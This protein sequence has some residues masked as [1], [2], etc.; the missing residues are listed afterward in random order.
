MSFPPGSLVSARGREW[1]VL[2]SEEG[3]VLRVRPLAGGEDEIAGL[4]MPLEWR[5]IAPATF[6]PP[7]PEQVGDAASA[8]VLCDA[9]RLKLRSGAAPFRS[10]GRVSV[11]PRPYQFV[12]LIMALRLDPVR[13]LI[14]DDVGVGKTIEAA[15]VAREMLDRGLARRLAVICPAHLCDQWERELHEKFALEAAVVQPAR[16]GRLER[17]LPRSDL[18]LYAHYRHLVVSIDFIKTDKNRHAFLRNAPDLIIVDEAHTAARPAGGERAVQQRYEFLKALTADPTRHILLVTATPHSGIEES[19][20]SLLGLLDPRFDTAAEVNRRDLVPHLVQRRRRDLEERWLGQDH[21]FPRRESS[22]ETYTLSDEYAALYVDVL[23]YCRESVSGSP[24]L[25]AQQQR[26]RYWAALALLRCVLSSPR[27]AAAVLSGRAKRLGDETSPIFDTADDV[28][29]TYLPQVLDPLDDEAAGD[30]TPSAPVDETWNGLSDT[31]RRRLTGLIR[32]AEQLAGP[33]RDHK[34]ARLIALLTAQLQAGAHPIVFCRFIA[35]AD[36]LEEQLKAALAVSFPDLAVRAVT[37]AAGG[38]DVRRE[39]IADLAQHERRV[40]VATD[41]LSEG[42]NLQDDF[43]AVLHYDLPWNPNRLE[44]REGRVDRFGQPRP[45]VNAV[46]LY[47]ANNEVDLVV[48]D[49]LL[50][51]AKQIRARLGVAVPVPYESEHV[52]G[53]LVETVLL[54]RPARGGLQLQLGLDHQQ[55]SR[56]HQAWD[57]AADREAR[58]RSY[59]AQQGIDPNEVATELAATDP[60]LGNPVTVEMFLRRA[61]QRLGGDLLPG[62]LPAVFSFNPGQAAP[63]LRARTGNAFPLAVTLDRQAASMPRDRQADRRAEYVGRTHPLV[64]GL[65]DLVLGRALGGDPDPLFARTGAIFTRAVMRR[66]AVALLRIRYN[67]RDPGNGFAEEVLLAAFS[68]ETDGLTWLTPIEQAG[69]DLI[70]AAEPAANM[71]N[72]E[73]TEHVRWA[74]DQLAADAGWYRPVVDARVAALQGAHTRLRRLARAPKL[75][76]QPHDP[77]DILGCYVL[78]PAAGGR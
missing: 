54:R 35:T 49:V 70:E 11:T 28:D 32:R 68:R 75:E 8:L 51:K 50:R 40:L 66:T 62:R 6:A 78:V 77:P 58:D 63:A 9:A 14:A 57:A 55:V 76:I 37:S 73:R 60:V 3:D 43:D 22:E 65:A 47:G 48:L 24:G 10:L 18:S 72:A 17:E 42:I 1:V 4:F 61:S 36:Y 5:G 74:L 26:V 53:A 13:L 31:D 16:I 64:E 25:R 69:R 41:C 45:A 15:L 2:P 71:S 20:R 12:P 39:R 23:D 46:L 29:L 38:D 52:V 30:Y 34:L 44:Q 21:P 27:A 56:L 59:F 7:D 67:M 19:F 33:A